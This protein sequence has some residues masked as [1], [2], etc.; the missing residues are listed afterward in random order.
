M[1]RAA[2]KAA[3]DIL[4][5]PVRGVFWKALGMT[6]VLF[7][8][9]LVAAEAA[10]AML[11]AFPWPW[12]TTALQVV[13]GLGLFVL[14]IFLMAPV[15]ALFAGLFLDDVAE[16]VERTGY[17]SDRAG[18]PL[19]NSAAFVTGL[20]FGLLVLG[21]NLLLLP[22]LLFGI[23]AALIVAANAYLLGREYFSMVAMRHMPV[24]QARSLR[25]ARAGQV[26]AAGLIPA[27]L[28]LVPVLNLFVPLFSTAYFVHIY[29]DI[30]GREQT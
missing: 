24:A 13:T 8:A 17:P 7:I 2:F 26:F 3:A 15:T 16:I 23:G 9:V 11:T 25:K 27:G 18:R 28:S 19:G 29:K 10:L 21:V 14:F 5:P 1:I 12:L 4:S 30:A 20:Q 22:F 6:I